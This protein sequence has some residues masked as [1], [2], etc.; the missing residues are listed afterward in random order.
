M[1]LTKQGRKLKRADKATKGSLKDEAQDM[2]VELLTYM[3]NSGNKTATP[4]L[5]KNYLNQKGL[6]TVGNPIVDAA[7]K[8]AAKPAAVGMDNPR[9]EPPVSSGDA[10]VNPNGDTG[11]PAVG[12][13]KAPEPLA[14]GTL[15]KTADGS[16]FKWLGN[17]WRAAKTGRMASKAQK[18]ELN[19]AAQTESI[20]E[21]EAEP[22]LSKRQVRGILKQVM[23]KA[24]GGKA[25]FTKSKFASDTA[26]GS[27]G[28]N[29]NTDADTTA[30]I[31]KLKAQ[32][33]KV[34]K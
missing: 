12:S 2:E 18:A 9:Q 10:P 25:G 3:K 32:G 31:D 21:A 5:V 14:P 20:S 22:T 15:A 28:N 23:T 13:P 1:G 26:T 33:Y 17:Q 27:S 8:A 4:S 11:A 7:A 34:T 16:E 24:Y 29:S 6:G 19:K 30:M